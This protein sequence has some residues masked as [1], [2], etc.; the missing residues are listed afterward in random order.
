MK[1]KKPV[2]IK[3]LSLLF[4]LLYIIVTVIYMSDKPIVT[5]IPNTKGCFGRLQK[6]IRK[7]L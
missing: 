6:I 4:V 5:Y 2:C 7:S 3:H 1:K